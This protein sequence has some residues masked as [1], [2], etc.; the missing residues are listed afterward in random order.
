MSGCV[1]AGAND[2][3][4]ETSDARATRAFATAYKEFSGLLAKRSG[5][6]GDPNLLAFV[7]KVSNY[8]VTFEETTTDYVVTFDLLPY[9][10]RLLNGG[11]GQY[12]VNKSTGKLEVV[13]M[14]E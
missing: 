11:G 13:E 8:K 5:E 4:Q 1:A 12:K 6:K 2:A 9:Q 14:Y 7:T 3:G 10:G